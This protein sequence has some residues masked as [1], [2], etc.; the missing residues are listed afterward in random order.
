MTDKTLEIDLITLPSFWAGYLVN[1]TVDGLSDK[2]IN[3]IDSFVKSLDGFYCVGTKD[4]EAWF[5]NR[6]EANS[7]PGMVETFIFHRFVK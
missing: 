1:A 3:E 7:I 5:A 6:N 4:D 2:E